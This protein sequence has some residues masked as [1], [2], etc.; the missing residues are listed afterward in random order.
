[1]RRPRLIILA[2]AVLFGPGSAIVYAER[3]E[4]FLQG[5]RARG[6]LELAGIHAESLLAKGA[7]SPTEVVDVQLQLHLTRRDQ[8]LASGDPARMQKSL[9]QLVGFI[10]SHP[11]DP[12]AES[13]RLE[14]VSLRAMLARLRA[15]RSGTPD[16]VPWQSVRDLKTALSDILTVSTRF[17]R[18]YETQRRE[19][20]KL[21][22]AIHRQQ[23]LGKKYGAL[24]GRRRVL[25]R[26]LRRYREKAAQADFLAADLQRQMAYLFPASHPTRREQLREAAEAFA[27][28]YDKYKNF[29]L[30]AY[31]GRAIEVECL[32][33]LSDYG[34]ARE[35][36]EAALLELKN[37]PLARHEKARQTVRDA[38]GQL[39]Y[40]RARIENEDKHYDRAHRIAQEG[41]QAF[42]EHEGI[43][44]EYGIAQI[45]KDK[46]TQGIVRIVQAARHGG[47][48]VSRALDA[49]ATLN[50][51]DLGKAEK[52]TDPIRIQIA[53]RLYQSERYA[54]VVQFLESRITRLSSEDS[55]LLSAYSI[56]AD[57]LLRTDRRDQA[58]AVLERFADRFPK[59][60]HGQSALQRAIAIQMSLAESTPPQD[61]AWENLRRLLGAYAKLYPTDPWIHLARGDLQYGQRQYR[62]AIEHYQAIGKKTGQYGD[63]RIKLGDAG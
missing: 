43:Q 19:Y 8:A 56:L 50:E 52:I 6:L 47:T 49:L 2:L 30:V 57:A 21:V 28:Y 24:I 40:L 29:L 44:L 5:L 3:E 46:K 61:T 27:A 63:A 1:M 58:V 62:A 15:Q 53:Q 31:L 51:S 35:R 33:L 45:H 7:L 34:E 22:R 59:Q 36:T 37:S 48:Y 17:A 55:L 9:E 10:R 38:G 4:E 25:E 12:R 42:A 54:Q 16:V 41:L 39:T 11:D 32:L 60:P 13:A 23:V 26:K 14:S 18:D 20:A